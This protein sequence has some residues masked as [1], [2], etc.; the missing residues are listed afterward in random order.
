M[1]GPELPVEAVLAIGAVKANAG[2]A[3][4]VAVTS[5]GDV[6]GDAD[7]EPGSAGAPAGRAG[8]EAIRVVKSRQAA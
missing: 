5:R 3:E 6:G 7:G 4:L 2:A 8:F 1:R